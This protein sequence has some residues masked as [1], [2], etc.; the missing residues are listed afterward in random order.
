MELQVMQECKRQRAFTGARRTTDCTRAISPPEG[1]R[2]SRDRRPLACRAPG[3][4][5]AHSAGRKMLARAPREETPGP[6]YWDRVSF[7]R[8]PPMTPTRRPSS[9]HLR[10]LSAAISPLE[11]R[12]GREDARGDAISHF[13]RAAGAPPPTS[14]T[15]P[16]RP[17]PPHPSP[18][19]QRSERLRLTSPASIPGQ[20]PPP[21]GC[22]QAQNA[23]RKTRRPME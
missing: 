15:N 4:G 13:S 16:D 8:A 17:R 6:T 10:P 21:Q 23:R 22:A 5:C 9:T 2:P 1:A 11:W 3:G 7:P 19:R 12:A 20:A 14:Q 18:R